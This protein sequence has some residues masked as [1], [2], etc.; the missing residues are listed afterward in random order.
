[1]GLARMETGPGLPVHTAGIAS[2]TATFK[3]KW[4][5]V[6]LAGCSEVPVSDVV[7]TSASRIS[8]FAVLAFER[9]SEHDGDCTGGNW[10]RRAG[11]K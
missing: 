8:C 6:R 7:E 10:S 4:L 11:A 5:K 3:V 9:P 1:M 2:Y